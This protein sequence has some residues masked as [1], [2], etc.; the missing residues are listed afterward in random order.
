MK[1]HIAAGLASI[2]ALAVNGAW[3][4]QADGPWMARIRAVDVMPVNQSTDPT[5]TLGNNAIHIESK[6]IPEVD[7]SYFFTKNIAAELILTYPQKHN[8]TLNGNNLGSFKELPPTLT[9]QY[10]FLPDSQFNP[11]LGA[12]VNYTRISDVSL[13]SGVTLDNNSWG[14]ALQAG[15]D[16]KVAQ[17]SYINFDVKKVYMKTDATSNGT[18]ISTINVD[19]L[20]IGIGYGFKF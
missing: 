16:V 10:H 6:I 5:G 7:F 15:F 19:P 2:A 3:A 17:N 9:A 11:Y 12:G 20:L 14:G 8:V 1:R 4:Q 13:G 18:K